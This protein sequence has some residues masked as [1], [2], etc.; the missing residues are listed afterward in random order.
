MQRNIRVKV[1]AIGEGGEEAP[2]AERKWIGIEERDTAAS[3]VAI[4]PPKCA[5]ISLIQEDYPTAGVI[6][7]PAI[8]LAL[9][10]SFN[11]LCNLW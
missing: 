3:Y 2:L 9:K 5:I 8:A 10:S 7:S 11:T 6:D 1:I 4:Y